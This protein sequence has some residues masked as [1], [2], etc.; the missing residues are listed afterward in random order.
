MRKIAILRLNNPLATHIHDELKGWLSGPTPLG[1]PVSDEL[2][3]IGSVGEINESHHLVIA[4]AYFSETTIVDMSDLRDF[5][6]LMDKFTHLKF[7][8]LSWFHPIQ[9]VQRFQSFFAY[10][11]QPNN[12]A[13]GLMNT[14]RVRLLQLPIDFLK[15]EIKETCEKLLT[16]K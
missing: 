10:A 15:S 14:T 16:I 4:M 11:D 2:A 3:I 7:I 13:N 9:D 1:L 6:P 12:A 5:L 8:F